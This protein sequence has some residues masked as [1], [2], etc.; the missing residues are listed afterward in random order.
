MI[1]ARTASRRSGRTNWIRISTV[2]A[3]PRGVGSRLIE[4]SLTRELGGQVRID[5]A[6]GGVV[7]TI[8]VPLRPDDAP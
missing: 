2:S 6:S 7:C 4:R 3:K 1:C 8:D 5:Y